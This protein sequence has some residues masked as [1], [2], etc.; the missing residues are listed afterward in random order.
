MVTTKQ[1]ESDSVTR[2]RVRLP[3]AGITENSTKKK[4]TKTDHVHVA[5]YQVKKE[6]GTETVAL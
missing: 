4:N 3:Q 6:T 1:S 5:N 2:T